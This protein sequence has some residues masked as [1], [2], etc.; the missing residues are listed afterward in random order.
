MVADVEKLDG[1]RMIGS[2]FQERTR[3]CPNDPAAQFERLRNR[4]RSRLSDFEIG[5][6]N[7]I[8]DC[9]S[10]EEIR[11]LQ[12]THEVDLVGEVARVWPSRRLALSVI[13]PGP[14]I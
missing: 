4:P 13:V 6:D 7:G 1:V 8:A 12:C 5:E 9:H 11:V 3:A 10:S 14:R 2:E